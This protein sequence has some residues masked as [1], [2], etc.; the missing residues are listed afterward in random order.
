MG[1]LEKII[2][3]KNAMKWQLCKAETNC[4]LPDSII[5][6]QQNVLHVFVLKFRAWSMGGSYQK[7]QVTLD[8]PPA[9]NN[10][11]CSGTIIWHR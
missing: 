9:L 6:Q 4:S 7:C 5:K 3:S 11:T 8:F 10:I 2:I 1:Q